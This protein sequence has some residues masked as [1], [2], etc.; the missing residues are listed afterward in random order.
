[1]ACNKLKY[2]HIIGYKLAILKIYAA[3]ARSRLEQYSY[4]LGGSSARLAVCYLSIYI[5]SRQPAL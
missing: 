2:G 1:M 5:H 3:V 4:W